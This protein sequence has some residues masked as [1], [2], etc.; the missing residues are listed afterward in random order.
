MTRREIVGRYRGALMGL[1]W[2][3]FN[4]V[5]M[6][7]VYTFCFGVVFKLR[8]PGAGEGHLEFAL[9]LFVGMILHG[10]LAE[11]LNSA[12]ALIVGNANFVKKVVFPLEILP[13]VTVGSALFHATV[14]IGVLLAFF[15]AVNHYLHWTVLWLPLLLAPFVLLAAGIAWF[16]AATGVYLRDIGQST[17][18]LTSLLLFL[19]PI[20]YPLSA[21]PEHLRPL[22]YLNPLSFVV[23]QA[24]AVVIHGRAPEAAGLALYA[25][26]GLAVAAGGYLWFQKLRRGFADVL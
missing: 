5:L 4:P 3:L 2:S 23:E 20:F 21:L 16:L 13:L 8:W 25:L 7:V 15:L 24:R 1:L 18:I 10:F 6:L 26:A 22:F 14:S 12:P 11:C 9:I 17:G 19:S